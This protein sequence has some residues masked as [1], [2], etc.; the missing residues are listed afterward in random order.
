[1]SSTWTCESIAQY[2]NRTAAHVRERPATAADVLWVAGAA[3]L[4][5]SS[6]GVFSPDDAAFL[7]AAL[8]SQVEHGVLPD[9]GSSGPPAAGPEF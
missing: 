8:R 7:I 4:S 6:E 3:D 9:V 1:M 2:A 5:A